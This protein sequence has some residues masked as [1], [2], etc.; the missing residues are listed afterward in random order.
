MQTYPL[1]FEPIL[2]EKI[3]GG[4]R[5]AAKLNKK[6]N[7]KQIGESWE[8]SGVP[9][10]VSVVVN[11]D[12]AGWSLSTLQQE[13]KSS[14]LG[15]ENYKRFGNDFPLLIKFLD[16]AKALSVQVHPDD[17]MAQKHH[18]CPGKTE[19]WY[20]MDHEA[21]AEIVLGLN[22]DQKDLGTLQTIDAQN[23]NSV[24]HTEKVTKGASY[25]IPAG[26]VHAIGSGILVAEI[27]QTSDVT[28]RIYDWGRT[29]S[30]GNYRELHTDMAIAATKN[31]QPQVVLPSDTRDTTNPIVNCDYFTT[32]ELCVNGQTVK[33]YTTLD[34]FVIF[35][36]T[37]GNAIITTDQGA[38]PITEGETVLLPANC[39]KIDVV[40]EAN[41][42][43]VYI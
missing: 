12:Y 18:N 37:A 35:I 28:Y 14:F 38:V 16:A 30:A 31:L 19:M 22:Q 4:T 43:E 36:C 13:F 27:Q 17:A 3:W 2:K 20:I 25:F 33:D 32:N 34:S 24:F 5:L 6:T 29:D 41:L 10:N 7:G 15:A 39:C 40:G 8:I 23:V 11:G 9:E 1:K 42:L 26:Q 21:D